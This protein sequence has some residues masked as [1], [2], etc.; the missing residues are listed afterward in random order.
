LQLLLR[1]LGQVLTA[2]EAA[3]IL[4]EA[5]L[6]GV[7]AVVVSV[8]AVLAVVTLVVPA[9]AASTEAVFARRQLSQVPVHVLAVTRTSVD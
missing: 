8:V 2:V 6:V 5:V 4:V 1:E 7:T 3:E 9:S